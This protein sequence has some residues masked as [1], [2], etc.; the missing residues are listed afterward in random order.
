VLL[1]AQICGLVRVLL[2]V[3]MTKR[4]VAEDLA[5]EADATMK[6][7]KRRSIRVIDALATELKGGNG[8]KKRSHSFCPYLVQKP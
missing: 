8:G 5:M 2:A 6:N 4:D 7:G 1:K 3:Q